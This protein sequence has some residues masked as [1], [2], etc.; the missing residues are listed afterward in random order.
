MQTTNGEEKFKQKNEPQYNNSWNLLSQGNT[1][2]GTTT[3]NPITGETTNPELRDESNQSP[4]KQRLF[5]SRQTTK[6][7]TTKPELR[8]KS[9]QS[10]IKHKLPIGNL[11]KHNKSIS[12]KLKPELKHKSTNCSVQ[13]LPQENSKQ[14]DRMNHSSANLQQSQTTQ[15]STY[16]IEK[17][18]F[19]TQGQYK[20]ES[21]QPISNC[22][23]KKIGSTTRTTLENF[24]YTIKTFQIQWAVKISTKK[25]STKAQIFKHLS[26]LDKTNRYLPNK[27]TIFKNKILPLMKSTSWLPT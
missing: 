6:V 16:P 24:Y 12:G 25:K 21:Y 19:K 11:C 17:N 1:I 9:N 5:P 14:G 4:G 10:P 26:T 13:Y 20:S 2:T 23:D 27:L 15:L 3:N 8:E 7:A 22:K 18:T